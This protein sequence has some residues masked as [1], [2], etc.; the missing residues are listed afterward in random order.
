MNNNT[1][2]R[3]DGQ[4]TPFSDWIRNHPELKSVAEGLY[5]TDVDYVIHK[6][7]VRNDNGQ[8]NREIKLLLLLEVKS[9]N[10]KPDAGQKET[11]FFIHQGL[12]SKQQM[13]S[14]LLKRHCTVW[15]FGQC[16]LRMSGERPDQSERMHWCVFDDKGMFHPTHVTEYTLCEIL[17]FDRD[18][19]D[20]SRYL[21]TRRHH[22]TMTIMIPETNTLFPIERP[23]LLRS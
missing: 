18:P 4:D 2:P 21:D 5:V 17:R 12:R 14:T 20:P 8:R 11:L 3:R 7:S 16:L 13:F 23:K 15:H 22:K 6:W 19:D 1:A 9:C 10:A